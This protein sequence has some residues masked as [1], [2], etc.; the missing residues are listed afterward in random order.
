MEIPKIIHQTYKTSK[1][2]EVWENTPETWQRFHPD[3]KYMF[4]TDDDN[5]ALVAE[6]F[7]WFLETYDGYEYNI[8][9]AD[10]I[11]PMILFMY[12][13]LYV[14]CDIQ[15]LRPVDSEMRGD[16]CLLLSKNMG[17]VTNSV[18]A[19]CPGHPFWINVLQQ[20]VL[21]RDDWWGGIK[22][23]TVM[24]TTGPNVI[25]YC[26]KNW[27]EAKG[28]VTMLPTD[29]FFPCSVCDPKPCG[30]RGAYV[31]H[32][33]GSSWVDPTGEFLT[34]LYCNP[35]KLTVVLVLLVMVWCY[36]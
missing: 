21:R 35:E 26:L 22:H 24:N 19:S 6:H 14:D 9:R 31:A 30:G 15:A 36:K 20:M 17:G 2:P 5:R 11:R 3:W 33:E 4:W 12:G 13:G 7:S 34:W 1:L 32:V 10:A 23:A 28:K 18:M 27:I 25:D 8:Q 16:L 29:K